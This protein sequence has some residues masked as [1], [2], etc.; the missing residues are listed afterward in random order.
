MG[1]LVV[2]QYLSWISTTIFGK[3]IF[4]KERYKTLYLFINSGMQ[5]TELASHISKGISYHV[6]E[7]YTIHQKLIKTP[8]SNIFMEL[9]SHFSIHIY[10]IKV[11]RHLLFPAV[12][13]AF[14]INVVDQW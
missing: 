3:V 8:Y 10:H 4:I 14:I 5:S 11:S 7:C 6:P 12:L 1:N 13:S 2:T 9:I